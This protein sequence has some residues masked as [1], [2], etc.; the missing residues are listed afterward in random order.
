MG[1]RVTYSDFLT[2]QARSELEMFYR[3]TV[4]EGVLLLSQCLSSDLSSGSAMTTKQGSSL[5]ASSGKRVG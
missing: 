5:P 1:R 4:E 3:L 2:E